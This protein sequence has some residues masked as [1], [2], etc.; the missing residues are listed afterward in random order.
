[1][2]CFLPFD[3]RPKGFQRGRTSSFKCRKNGVGLLWDFAEFR[4][5]RLLR[6][7]YHRSSWAL[8]PAGVAGVFG[9]GRDNSP[10]KSSLLIFHFNLSIIESQAFPNSLSGGKEDSEKMAPHFLQVR[11]WGILCQ[12]K[13]FLAM[14]VRLTGNTGSKRLLGRKGSK[15]NKKQL[16]VVI[17]FGSI[18]SFLGGAFVQFIFSPPEVIAKE[19]VKSA[20]VLKAN[21]FLLTNQKGQIRASLSLDSF[22]EKDERPALILFDKDG[23]PRAT[24][25]LGNNDSPE[26][27]L[28]DKNGT[29]RFN[30]GLTPAGNAGMTVNNGNFEKLLD[31]NTSSGI[32]VI[33][34]RGEHTSIRWTAP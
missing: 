23:K 19:S 16:L 24:L 34:V 1:M 5:R 30:F 31:V 25:F 20:T 4:F 8:T 2:P 29:N 13:R 9:K 3:S 11:E 33:M 28:Y 6:G 17:I 7:Q 18:S 12:V 14:V 21:K 15:M 22:G 10:R 27:A 32:P 26:M